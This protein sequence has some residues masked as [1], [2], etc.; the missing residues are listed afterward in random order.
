MDYIASE[1]PAGQVSNLYDWWHY[2]SMEII[3][4]LSFGLMFNILQDGASNAYIKDLYGSLQI[5]P[6]R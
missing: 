5:E 6:I 3:C 2:L 4:E 1:G